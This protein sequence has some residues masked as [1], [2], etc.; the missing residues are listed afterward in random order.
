LELL[1]ARDAGG[2]ARGALALRAG[3]L[4]QLQSEQVSRQGSV[5]PTGLQ[6]LVIGDPPTHLGR[7]PGARREAGEVAE[8]LKSFDWNV[9]EHISQADDEAATQWVEIDN[10]LHAAAYR[11]VHIAA[12]GVFD[13]EEPNRSGVVTGPG[14]HHRLTAIDFRSMSVQ[15]DLVFLNCCH[16]GRLESGPD[17]HRLHSWLD[18][19]GLRQPHKLAA[20]VATQL[21]QN[22]VKAVVVAGWEVDDQ[23][24]AA[25]ADRLYRCL[26]D[27]EPFGDAVRKARTTAFDVAGETSNTW[28]AYQCYGD[29]DFQLVTGSR[30]RR[31]RE[32]IVSDNQLIQ[33]LQIL[34]GDAGQADD[35]HIRRL[36]EELENVVEGAGDRLD[37]A[38]VTLA[39]G[40]AYDAVGQFRKAAEWY[41]RCFR[42]PDGRGELRAIEQYTNMLVR[43]AASTTD[44]VAAAPF[45]TAI[46]KLE[47]IIAA[48]GQTSARLALLGSVYKKLAVMLSRHPDA[49][50][51]PDSTLPGTAAAALELATAR[52]KDAHDHSLTRPDGV[53]DVHSANVWLQLTYAASDGGCERA[54]HLRLCERL[55]DVATPAAQSPTNFWDRSQLGDTLLTMALVKGDTTS[56]TDIAH[57][58][59]QYI[60][61]FE[62]RSTIRVSSAASQLR[63]HRRGCRSPGRRRPGLR[64][65]SSPPPPRRRDHGRRVPERRAPRA[66][67]ALGGTGPSTPGQRGRRSMRPGQRLRRSRPVRRCGPSRLCLP[68]TSRVRSAPI[69]RRLVGRIDGPDP[70]APPAVVG[71]DCRRRDRRARVHSV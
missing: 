33:T 10:L 70:P 45:E 7:L 48:V 9:S 11:V 39:I 68:G 54:D 38:H 6:A 4:R 29:P 64:A 43:S 30:P 47:A 56:R 12:H 18:P 41:E 55:L 34:T 36:T 40:D 60:A 17:D 61:A 31:G 21:M 5:R 25:F 16:L 58:V 66:R 28:G 19:A 71:R 42:S 49:A 44:H 8:L 37:S 3:F 14:P 69:R 27:A 35:D 15:P 2:K 20:T 46:T 24:A 59:E 50:M 63:C 51:P 23:A 57:A 52:Y 65:A 22:G 1:A 67:G 32:A 26:L 62:N 53:P 13:S